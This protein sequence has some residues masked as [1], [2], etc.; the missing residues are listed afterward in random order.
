MTGF[1]RF[2]SAWPKSPRKG[3]KSVCLQRWIK[4]HHES[5]SETI[6]AHV[7]YMKTTMDWLK[8]DGRYIPAPLVYINGQKWDGAEIPPAEEFMQID[9]EAVYKRQLE[10]SI[11]AFK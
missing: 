5:Q 2:W 3:G 1:E 4:C 6:V 11:R 10:A 7:K 8:D 9:R